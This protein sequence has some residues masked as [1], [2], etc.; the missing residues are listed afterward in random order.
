MHKLVGK[1][2]RVYFSRLEDVEAPNFRTRDPAVNR[3]T[4]QLANCLLMLDGLIGI[5]LRFRLRLIEEHLGIELLSSYDAAL[6]DTC[7]STTLL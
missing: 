2:E 7:T 6:I 1:G 4:I 3:E 5:I